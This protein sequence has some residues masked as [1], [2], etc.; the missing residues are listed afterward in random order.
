[1]NEKER[2]FMIMET[3]EL[4]PEELEAASGGASFNINGS[5]LEVYL[6]PGESAVA[7]LQ[8]KLYS[9]IQVY[10]FNLTVEDPQGCLMNAAYMLDAQNMIGLPRRC[11]V[12]F[13]MDGFTKVIITGA[14]GSV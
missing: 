8:E 13:T 11:N 6:D 9:G 12:T 3:K 10:G 1:M 14:Y 4:N 7:A 5:N 2:M